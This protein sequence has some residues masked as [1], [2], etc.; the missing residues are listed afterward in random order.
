MELLE[1]EA[2]LAELT[3]LAE[4]ARAGDGRL[5]LVAGEAGVG[6]TALVERLQP[7]LPDARWSWSACDGLFTPLPLGPLFDL[8][9]QLGGELAALCAADAERHRLF[10]ALLSQVSAPGMLDVVVIEDVHWADEATAD[11]LRFLGQRL[12]GAP[13]LLIVTYRDEG[14]ATTHP[15]RLALGDLTGIAGRIELLPLSAEAVRRLAS[16][17]SGI[18]PAE[19]YRL[20]GGNPFFVT[21][22]LQA[23]LANVPAAARDAVLA[24]AARLSGQARRLV[25]LAALAGNRVDPALID[26][27]EPGA[28]AAL[29]EVLATGLL[30]ADGARPRFRHEMTRLAIEQGVPVHRRGPIHARILAALADLGGADAAR[31]AFHAEAAGDGPAVLR[32]ALTAARQ[33]AALGAHRAA[34]A[35]Y[36][37]ALRFTTGAARG[38]AASNRTVSNRALSLE[39]GQLAELHDDLASALL[40][41][42]RCEDAE[43]AWSRALSL[44]RESGNRL[45]QG[46]TMSRLAGVLPRLC[47]GEV[48]RLGSRGG[49][50]VAAPDRLGPCPAAR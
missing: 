12:K 25:D 6:K 44:W 34:V 39:A 20:T 8:A 38:A 11:L 48:H 49:H 16:P 1:R 2:A 17:A 28:A 47:R 27:L 18:D 24:R 50:R 4:R 23:G 5:V 22:V 36:E 41:I 3:R 33:A 14:L 35:Q 32:H 7:D 15:L 19:L 29:D 26:L 31:M 40:L 30:C 9:D 10:G 37:R 43:A 13:V 46:R 45:R 21:E 42:D